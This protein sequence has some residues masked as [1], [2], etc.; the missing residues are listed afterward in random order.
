MPNGWIES[1]FPGIIWYN[2]R[3]LR[4]NLQK[5]FD[6]ILC[7]KNSCLVKLFF[8]GWFLGCILVRISINLRK[9]YAPVKPSRCPHEL[10]HGVHMHPGAPSTSTPTRCPNEGGAYTRKSGKRTIPG[11]TQNKRSL[12]ALRLWR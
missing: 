11:E 9:T 1:M 4:K 10:R 5:I 12:I 7:L 3:R 2:L 6:A 8:I